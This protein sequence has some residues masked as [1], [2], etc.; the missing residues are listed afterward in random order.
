MDA[1]NEQPITFDTAELAKEKGCELD[2]YNGDWEYENEHGD[3]Y[4]CNYNPSNKTDAVMNNLRRKVNCTQALLQR[5]LREEHDLY[6]F[7]KI[8]K[9]HDGLYYL[10]CDVWEDKKATYIKQDRVQL[11]YEDALEIGLLEALK[12]VTAE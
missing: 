10:G 3:T 9:N 4:V 8:V 2:L 6:V 5:W 11:N 12:L 7:P 1:M